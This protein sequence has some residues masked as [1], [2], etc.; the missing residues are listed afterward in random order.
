[1]NIDE[2]APGLRSFLTWL[3]ERE[4][5]FVLAGDAALQLYVPGRRTIDLELIMSAEAL[6][7]LPELAISDRADYS[8]HGTF[9]DVGVDILLSGNP[10][11]AYVKQR[12]AE[13]TRIA[14][15]LIACVTVEGLI[16]LKLHALPRLFDRGDFL[17][18]GMNE[19]D[20][21]ALVFIYRPNMDELLGQLGGFLGARDL[22]TVRDGVDNIERLIERFDSRIG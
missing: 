18:V 2:S 19:T 4:V 3:A 12:H 5:D 20:V 10:F 15:S 16:L 1:M 17:G 7:R 6:S 21:S 22:Q 11:F 14:E 8:A 13:A 9:A